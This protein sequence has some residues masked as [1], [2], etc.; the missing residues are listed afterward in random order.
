M[1]YGWLENRF[2]ADLVPFLIL[3]SAIGMVDIWRRL[4]GKRRR[5]RSG[6]LAL[7]TALGLF[8]ITANVEIA[9]TPQA[10]WSRS[11]ILHYVEFQ[12]T[13]SDL[14]GHPPAA[15]IT[16]GTTL[17]NYAPADQLFVVG[18]CASL[19]IS[20]GEGSPDSHISD[21][22][23]SPD[24]LSF[25]PYAIFQRLVWYPVEL[26]PGFHHTLELTF[27]GPVQELGQSVPLATVG[28][29]TISVEPWNR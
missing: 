2:V 29:T 20:D 11:Q 1:I 24:S 21:G 14:T 16:R 4:E 23:G 18:N 5:A 27:H 22:E 9:S 17:P 10:T 28:T 15:N 12:N 8:G 3:A 26:G 25:P 7:V 13:I 6:M 19:Y